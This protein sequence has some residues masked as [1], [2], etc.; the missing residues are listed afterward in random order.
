MTV[1]F[2]KDFFITL[3]YLSPILFVLILAI[4]LLG[5]VIGRL[6]RWSKTDAVYYAFITATTVGYG[7]FHPKKKWS[8]ILAIIDAFVGLITTGVIVAVA[9]N[10]ISIAAKTYLST[11]G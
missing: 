6:E 9:V 1:L 2:L 11:V 5:L 7:D 8:K 3:F 10:S 4:I